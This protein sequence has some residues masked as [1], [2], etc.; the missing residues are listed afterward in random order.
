MP[1]PLINIPQTY[2]RFAMGGPQHWDEIG[3]RVRSYCSMILD[4]K[5]IESMRGMRGGYG[6]QQ[7]GVAFHHMP[8]ADD[9]ARRHNPIFAGL[10]KARHRNNAGRGAL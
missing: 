3:D 7:V 2:I 5:I 1:T 6:T 4:N 9:P 8:D 10:Q